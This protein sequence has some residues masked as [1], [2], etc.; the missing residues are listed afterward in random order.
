[1]GSRAYTIILK[2]YAPYKSFFNSLK[3]EKEFYIVLYIVDD[4][5][6]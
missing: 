4:Y 3:R 6:I 5:I 1:M 2:N